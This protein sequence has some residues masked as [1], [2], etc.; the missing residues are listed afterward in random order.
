MDALR[1]GSAGDVAAMS[2]SSLGPDWDHCDRCGADT[3]RKDEH[4]CPAE[5]TD[6]SVADHETRIADLEARVSRLEAAS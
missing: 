4:R 3:Y 2:K 6:A 5:E 1:G